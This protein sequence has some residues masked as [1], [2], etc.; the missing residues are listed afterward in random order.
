MT[1][2]SLYT[3]PELTFPTEVGDR[4]DYVRPGYWLPSTIRR[5]PDFYRF[6]SSAFKGNRLENS[7]QAIHLE[8]EGEGG[9]RYRSKASR[10]LRDLLF[11]GVDV[12]VIQETKIVYDVNARVLSSDFLDYSAYA[13]QLG[14]RVSLPVKHTLG[15]KGGY[16]ICG[17]GE[18]LIAADIAVSSSSCRFVAIYAPDGAS[19]FFPA[20]GA[21]PGEFVALRLNGELECRPGPVSQ[22]E[23]G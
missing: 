16:C 3:A 18:Q 2:P 5:G 10:L 13:E 9:L 7:C 11:F 4:K 14:R 22:R 21:V 15:A 12:P 8:S 20:V 19:L 17:S 1:D 6:P 23:V